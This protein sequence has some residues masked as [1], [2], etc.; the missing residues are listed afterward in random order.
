[1][2]RKHKVSTDVGT[3]VDDTLN[4]ST[5]LPMIPGSA[6]HIG[7]DGDNLQESLMKSS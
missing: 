1:M 3:G 6:G 7:V 2:N 4:E 5:S